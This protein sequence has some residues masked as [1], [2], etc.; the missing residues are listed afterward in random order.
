[1][2][3]TPSPSPSRV[4][5]EAARVRH[6]AAGVLAQYIQDLAH[7]HPADASAAS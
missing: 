1:M 2:S 3:T 4:Q 7:P 6:G 5:S